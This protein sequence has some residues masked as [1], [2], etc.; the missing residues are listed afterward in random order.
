MPAIV[1]ERITFASG[2]L[3]LSGLLSYPEQE[4]PELAVLVCSPHPHFAGDMDNNVVRAVAERLACRAVVLRFDYRGVGTS[5]IALGQDVSVFDYWT[6]IEE[7][8]NYDDPVSDV[9]AAAL[10]LA[11]AVG[12]LD[13]DFCIVGYSF[14][15]ATG[16][17]FGHEAGAVKRMVALAPPL[18]KVS[19]DF[20]S[21]CLKPSLH[22][23]GKNDFLYSD[24]K[25]SG[26]RQAVGPAAKVVVLDEA[27]H[28][29]RGDEDLL[30]QEVDR[31]LRDTHEV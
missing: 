14:G 26:Y 28:F 25:L 10:A 11:S 9:E 8:R 31:F 23:V 30:A 13:V 2:S 1:E 6:E 20:L 17:L 3:Q 24:E 16:M 22:L 29:F 19:F 12:A 27:D 21:S 5:E 7:A 4:T 15:A 18:G